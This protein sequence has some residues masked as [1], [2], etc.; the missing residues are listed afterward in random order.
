MDSHLMEILDCP[1]G[2][3]ELHTGQ[4]MENGWE[5][6]W[7]CSSPAWAGSADGKGDGLQVRAPK[8]GL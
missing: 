2:S 1:A 5:K 7:L 3:P 8:T 6:M 4:K